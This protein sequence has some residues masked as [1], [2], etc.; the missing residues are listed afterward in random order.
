MRR[1]WNWDRTDSWSCN[2]NY[3]GDNA[4]KNIINLYARLYFTVIVNLGNVT[5][6]R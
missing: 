5:R 2:L 3:I 1:A 6:Q 4:V